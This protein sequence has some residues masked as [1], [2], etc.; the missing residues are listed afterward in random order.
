MHKVKNRGG[1]VSERGHTA[2][3]NM[4]DHLAEPALVIREVTPAVTV[5]AIRLTLNAPVV[6]IKSAVS[7]LYTSLATVSYI[8]P[9]KKLKGNLDF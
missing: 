9:P 5:L 4:Q 1:G 7:K 3:N 8:L 6:L 2:H